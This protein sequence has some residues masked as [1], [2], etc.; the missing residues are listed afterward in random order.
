[1]LM[2][3]IT[4]ARPSPPAAALDLRLPWKHYSRT[5]TWAISTQWSFI[6][7]GYRQPISTTA[8]FAVPHVRILIREVDVDYVPEIWNPLW[9][10]PC[11]LATPARWSEAGRAIGENFD[12]PYSVQ[13]VSS[14]T[15]ST[16][17][18]RLKPRSTCWLSLCDHVVRGSPPAT[19]PYHQGVW[20]KGIAHQLLRWIT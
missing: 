11:V 14:G 9:G 8:C 17:D 4:R 5:F 19:R 3:C 13:H 2:A 12:P 15:I 7:F 20:S 18:L 1:M 16:R 10:A 6:F